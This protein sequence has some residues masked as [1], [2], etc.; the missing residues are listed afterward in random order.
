MDLMADETRTVTATVDTAGLAPGV[1][2]LSIS[3]FGATAGEVVFTTT[4]GVSVPD[5]SNGDERAQAV[6]ELLDRQCACRQLP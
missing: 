5:L 6:D 1:Y 2:S 3:V 4:A